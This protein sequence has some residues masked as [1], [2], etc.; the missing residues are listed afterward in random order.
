MSMKKERVVTEDEAREILARY[1]A[2]PLFE[3]NELLKMVRRAA[4]NKNVSEFLEAMKVVFLSDISSSMK[5]LLR[6]MDKV[7]SDQNSE[8][9]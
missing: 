7:N 3:A 4:G 9:M 8:G 5:E 6:G 2:K 1:Y